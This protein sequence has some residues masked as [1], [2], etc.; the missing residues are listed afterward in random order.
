MSLILSFNNQAESKLLS[1]TRAPHRCQDGCFSHLFIFVL[2]LG[3]INFS[4]SFNIQIESELLSTNPP[5]LRCQED[6]FQLNFSLFLNLDSSI[7][8]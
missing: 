7:S 5:P 4:L 8:A 3:L 6:F 2:Q 1:M